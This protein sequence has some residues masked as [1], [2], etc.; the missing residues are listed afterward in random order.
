MPLRKGHRSY[1]NNSTTPTIINLEL[2]Q[3]A[4]LAAV[5]GSQKRDLGDRYQA[6][7]MIQERI[8][9]IDRRFCESYYDEIPEGLPPKTYEELVGA[10]QLKTKS[11]AGS[12][13]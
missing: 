9:V 10:V 11:A 1:H 2:R 3:I 8:E 13:N 12:S 4:R 7:G 5:A 6:L